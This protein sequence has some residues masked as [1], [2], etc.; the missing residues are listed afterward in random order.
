M[1][2]DAIAVLE[3]DHATLQELFARVSHPDEDRAAVLAELLR[4]LSAHVAAEKQ[5]IVP[6]LRDR[7][8]GGEALAEQIGADHDVMERAIVLIERRKVNSTDVPDLV[9]ELLDLTQAHVR[10]ADER[11]IPLLRDSLA[12]AERAELGAALRSDEVQLST[13]PHPHLP[14]TGPAAKV[15]RAAAQL[16]DRARDASTELHRPGS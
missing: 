5:L 12:E 7:G 9:N 8:D 15:T 3:N 4:R 6:L 14:D 16:V 10:T 1:E 2:N 11:L 13:H